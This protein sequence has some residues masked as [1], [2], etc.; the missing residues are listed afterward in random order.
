MSPES[1][2]KSRR[3]RH[4]VGHDF[5]GLGVM[6]FVMFTCQYPFSKF[7]NFNTVIQA[8]LSE[9]SLNAGEDEA[10]AAAP[11]GENKKVNN[12]DEGSDAARSST[13][14][15]DA[16]LELEAKA[17]PAHYV[18]DQKTLKKLPSKEAR[19][20]CRSLLMMNEKYVRAQRSA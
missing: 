2:N 19:D 11:K 8:H 4:G 13:A 16:A 10:P 12:Y 20:L 7:G 9:L 3:G 6:I 15:R 17:L 18:L 1:R 5:F 14:M